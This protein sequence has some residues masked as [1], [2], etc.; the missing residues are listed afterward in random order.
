[1]ISQ[2]IVDVEK[3]DSINHEIMLSTTEYTYRTTVL[4]I[5]TISRGLNDRMYQ[6][7]QK[8]GV[9]DA[10]DQVLYY[11]SKT[12]DSKCRQISQSDFNNRFDEFRQKDFST[13]KETCELYHYKDK[14]DILASAFITIVRKKNEVTIATIEF[15]SDI[16]AENFILPEWLSPLK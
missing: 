16:E 1:M 12:Y 13:V 7:L 2:F 9:D 5:Q 3:Y 14:N 8:V 11:L 6:S 10:P 4:A 15:N